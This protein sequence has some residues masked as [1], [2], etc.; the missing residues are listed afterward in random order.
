MYLCTGLCTEYGS[1]VPICIIIA[2]LALAGTAGL[3][4]AT[5]G[6]GEGGTVGGLPTA[7]PSVITG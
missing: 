6:Q 2:V 1:Y 3:C 4:A 7:V 5:A